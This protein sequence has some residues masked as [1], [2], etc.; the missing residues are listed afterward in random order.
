MRDAKTLESLVFSN[1]DWLK[2]WEATNPEAP[3]SFDFRGMVRSLLK[4]YDQQTSVPFVIEVEGHVV[5]Q[6]NVANILYGAVSSAV[7]GYW[8]V[9][10]LADLVVAGR[11]FAPTAV[12]LATDYLMGTMGLHRVEINIVPENSKSL[13]VVEKLGFRHEGLKKRY[14]HINGSWH[15]HYVFALTKEDLAGEPSKDAAVLNRWQSGR[16]PNLSYPWRE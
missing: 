15:D 9:P 2:P 4:Q 5:G 3:Q 16:V 7:I 1:R 10:Q 11:G 6:L 13:R 8:L 14:I 12:A